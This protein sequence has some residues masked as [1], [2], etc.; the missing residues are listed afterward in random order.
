[1]MI[2]MMMMMLM[3]IVI[4]TVVVAAMVTGVEV[5]TMICWRRPLRRTP[6]KHQGKLCAGNDSH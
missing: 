1:M 2:M 6:I 4:R 5:S 3:M